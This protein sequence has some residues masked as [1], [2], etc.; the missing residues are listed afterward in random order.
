MR[1]QQGFWE[2][3]LSVNGNGRKK[4]QKPEG[5]D[6]RTACGTAV[7][8]PAALQLLSGTLPELRVRVLPP[9]AADR[10]LA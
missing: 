8:G 6:K 3:G 9:T 2:C 7:T 5:A 4:T 10:K 1:G